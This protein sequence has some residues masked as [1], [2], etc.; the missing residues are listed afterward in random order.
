LWYTCGALEFL[1][2][3]FSIHPN[4]I[5]TCTVLPYSPM[6][7]MTETTRRILTLSIIM[8]SYE[9]LANSYPN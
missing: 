2:A 6:Q 8:I 7:E 9:N 1:F 5:V 3:R 4:S